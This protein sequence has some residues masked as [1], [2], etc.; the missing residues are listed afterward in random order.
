MCLERLDADGFDQ[1]C[2]NLGQAGSLES[3]RCGEY[4]RNHPE[5][6]EDRLERG[7]CAA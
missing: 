5:R 7:A 3:V 1:T 4:Q 2:R 6:R